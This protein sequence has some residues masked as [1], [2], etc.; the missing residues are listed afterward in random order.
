MIGVAVSAIHSAG[1]AAASFIEVPVAD[2][3]SSI[4]SQTE[5]PPVVP[6]VNAETHFPSVVN[7]LRNKGIRSYCVLPLTAAGKR[8]GALGLGSSRMTAFG[9]AEADPDRTAADQAQQTQMK[10]QRAQ[11]ARLTI[12]VKAIQVSLKANGQAGSLTAK[13]ICRWSIG[14]RSFV[15]TLF[16]LQRVRRLASMRSVRIDEFP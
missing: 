1:L 4:A 6:D 11:I 7:L 15:V 16:G 12:P 10:A 3:P 2:S 9:G 8:L 14:T 13:G 5:R